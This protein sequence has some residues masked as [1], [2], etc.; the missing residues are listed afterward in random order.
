MPAPMYTVPVAQYQLLAAP[1]AAAV[2]MQVP[3]VQL[4]SCGR[5]WK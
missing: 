3:A 2:L 5:L 1:G 4:A